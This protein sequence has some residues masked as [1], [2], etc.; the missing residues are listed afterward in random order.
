M[1]VQMNGK[2]AGSFVLWRQKWVDW[3]A[4]KTLK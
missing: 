3:I 2:N 1:K 4:H